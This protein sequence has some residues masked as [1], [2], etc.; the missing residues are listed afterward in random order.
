MWEQSPVQTVYVYSKTTAVMIPKIIHYC[1]F[2]PRPFPEKA[3]LCIDSWKKYLP[4][5]A[6]MFWNEDNA[7]I[8]HPFAKAAIK[9]NKYAFVADYVRTWA[10]Y[11]YG[12]IYMDTDML[13]IRKLDTLLSNQVFFAYEEPDRGYINVAIWGAEKHGSFV[14]E[15]L[16]FYDSHPFD[17]SNVFA[18]TIPRIVTEVYNNYS[19]PQEIALLNYDSF[20]PFPGTKRRQSNY[21]DYATPNTYGIHL[22]DFSWLTTKERIIEHIRML[23]RWLKK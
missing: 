21:L 4:D 8:N 19:Q 5:Y 7:P 11:N 17:V 18:C 6:V 13:I 15:V 2:G 12:G 9:A 10:L 22:W 3:K 23:I 1:W 16:D 20:Y 14:K